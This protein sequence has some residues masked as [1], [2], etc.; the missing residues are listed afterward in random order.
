MVR[1]EYTT[2]MVLTLLAEASLRIAEVTEGLSPEQLRRRIGQDDWSIN[3]ILAH[4]RSCADMWGD[5][6]A[7]ILAADHPTFKAINPRTWIEQTDYPNLEFHPSFEA[8]AAQRAGLVATLAALPPNDW[9]RL[10][11][12]TGAG[13]PLER[14]VRSFAE[15]LVLHERAHIK[16]IGRVADALRAL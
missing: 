1:A 10:A 8:F 2:D 12:V 6:I 15:R 9:E 16:Q 11:T 3:D 7:R 5:G 14:T 4:L 13:K